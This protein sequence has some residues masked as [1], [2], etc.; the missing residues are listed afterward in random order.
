MVAWL[1]LVTSEEG[2]EV[3]RGLANQSIEPT[4]GSRFFLFAFVSQRRLPPVAHARRSHDTGCHAAVNILFFTEGCISRHDQAHAFR[5]DCQRS[6]TG[7]PKGVGTVGALLGPFSFVKQHST[8]PGARDMRTR[9]LERKFGT[10]DRVANS[11][12]RVPN[13][14]QLCR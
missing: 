10:L 5:A 9:S 1:W 7:S 8:V 13:S 11:V 3:K 6:W 14:A 4:G 2:V 12:L